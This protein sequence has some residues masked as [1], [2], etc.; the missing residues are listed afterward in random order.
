[1]ASLSL[2]QRCTCTCSSILLCRARYTFIISD[3]YLHYTWI[4]NRT[5][6]RKTKRAINKGQSIFVGIPKVNTG[7]SHR[8]SPIT[9]QVS[10]LC[11]KYK[12]GSKCQHQHGNWCSQK[13]RKTYLFIVLTNLRDLQKF[14]GTHE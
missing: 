11:T 2:Q 9:L 10:E 7:S 5:G 13:W 6:T 8:I 4:D 14:H 1:M 12:P 3:K